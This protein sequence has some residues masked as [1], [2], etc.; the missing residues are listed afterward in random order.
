MIGGNKDGGRS[1]R[2][3]RIAYSFYLVQDNSTTS[4]RKEIYDVYVGIAAYASGAS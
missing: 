1:D 4:E 3:S 2:V